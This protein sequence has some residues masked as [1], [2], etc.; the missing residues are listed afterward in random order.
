MSR[1]MMQALE[2]GMVI[3]STLGHW[4]KAAEYAERGCE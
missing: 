2:V 1:G 3:E 4:G